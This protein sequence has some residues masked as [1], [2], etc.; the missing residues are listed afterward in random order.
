MGRHLDNL[1]GGKVGPGE[2][3]LECVTETEIAHLLGARNDQEGENETN[4]NEEE[5][6]GRIGASERT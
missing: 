3:W 2:P 4:R 1:H 6:G 5:D